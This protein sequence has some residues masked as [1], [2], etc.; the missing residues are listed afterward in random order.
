MVLINILSHLLQN[1]FFFSNTYRV[2]YFCWLFYFMYCVLDGG[3]IARKGL[4]IWLV[5][6]ISCFMGYVNGILEGYLYAYDILNTGVFLLTFFSCIVVEPRRVLKEREVNLIFYSIWLSS[7]AASV[8]MFVKQG[9][10]ISGALNGSEYASWRIYS[11][12][13]QRNVY[14]GFCFISIVASLYL[15]VKKR[16]FIYI[17]SILVMFFIVFVTGS[18]TA[19]ISSLIFLS[20][21]IFKRTKNKYLLFLGACLVIIYMSLQS[22]IMSFVQ[23]KFSH[24]T[25]SGMDS[26]FARIMMWSSGIKHLADGPGFIFGYGISSTAS[27]LK[28]CGYTV[29]SFHNVYIE[30]FFEGGLMLLLL[31]FTSV[32]KAIKRIRYID[33]SDFRDIWFSAFIAYLFYCMLEAGQALFMSNFFSVT[34]TVLFILMP[35]S[36]CKVVSVNEFH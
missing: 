25:S 19:L 28:M 26:G 5:C 22:D 2:S 13:R 12:F 14:A 34:T 36:L 30:Y 18:R 32:K 7:I 15:Y 9:S 3:K 27:F 16:Q 17:I 4:H 31:I 23:E 10:L 21:Y 20:L 33:N 24:N 6:M 11:F 29:E 35:Q 1:V 8:Y